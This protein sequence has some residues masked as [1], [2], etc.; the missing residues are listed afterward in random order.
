M[1]QRGRSGA[2]ELVPDGVP[3]GRRTLAETAAVELHRL[4]LSGELQA[5]EPLRLADLADRL[6]MS[7]MPI[8]EA[9]RRLDALGLVE[10]TPH[11]GTRVRP[12]S[13]EDFLDTYSTRLALESLAIRQAANRCT[14]DDLAI[15]DAALA[16]HEQRLERGDMIEA[17]AAHTRFHFTLYQAS[18]SR[19][20]PRAIEPVWQNSE[21]Y[22]F[23][24]PSD[25]ARRAESHEEHQ[26]M[27][28]ACRQH[29]AHTAAAALRCHLEGAASRILRS[30]DGDQQR[31]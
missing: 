25:P 12:L 20:L 29:D 5:G 9:L 11:K 3:P 30:L 19:W 7:H 27:L 21:R 28:D 10:M 4:I 26:R 15:A 16:L 13:H 22:R 8:R 6:Q 31:M 1:T 2:L 14:D 17:R 23:A 24:T 18:G